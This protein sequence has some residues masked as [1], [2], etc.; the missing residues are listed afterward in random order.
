MHSGKEKSAR[1]NKPFGVV[2]DGM[3]HECES[4]GVRNDIVLYILTLKSRGNCS[5][6]APLWLHLEIILNRLYVLNQNNN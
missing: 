2:V 1:R 5:L 6:L 4:L 3:A